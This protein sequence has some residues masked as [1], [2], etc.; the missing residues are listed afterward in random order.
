LTRS[1]LAV[2]A[3]IFILAG[4]AC[5]EETTS[6]ERSNVN[7]PGADGGTN[8]GSAGEAGAPD[9]EDGRDT[10]PASCYAACSNSTFTC[11]P[12]ALVVSVTPDS[13]GCTG[14]VGPAGGTQQ[15]MKLDCGAKKVCVDSACVDGRYSATT[16]AYTPSG[17]SQVVCTRD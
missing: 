2:T 11:V 9:P 12:G 15:T 10:E 16:F 8:D 6:K 3:V 7:Q 4:A 1:V 14:T 13:A 17:G 5:Q